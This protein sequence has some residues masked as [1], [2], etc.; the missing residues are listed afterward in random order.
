MNMS[1]A[2]IVHSLQ[3]CWEIGAVEAVGSRVAC[4]GKIVQDCVVADP[5]GSVGR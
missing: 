5:K 3:F 1:R 4:L 2:A